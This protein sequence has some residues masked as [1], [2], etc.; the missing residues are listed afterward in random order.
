MV[1]RVGKEAEIPTSIGT[2]I[3]GHLLVT[4]RT[5]IC[6]MPK[7]LVQVVVG[8]VL[9]QQDVLILHGQHTMVG[10]VG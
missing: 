3:T 9:E 8:H 6:L 1:I 7:F 5:M 10:L 4:S 2:E